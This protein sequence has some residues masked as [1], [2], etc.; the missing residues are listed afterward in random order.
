MKTYDVYFRS[1]LQW[2]MREFVADSPAQAL[3][4]ARRFAAENPESLDL[5][6]YEACDSEINEIEVCDHRHN[7]VAVWFDEDMRLR[8]AARDLLDAGQL[9]IDRWER[10]DLAEAV[11]ELD[12]AIAKAKGGAP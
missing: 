7:S 12:A 6:F 11:R 5:D 8:L 9:V 1:D 4:L 2:G 10:G 3:E